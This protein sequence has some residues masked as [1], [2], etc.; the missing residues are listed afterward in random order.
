M[1]LQDVY[2]FSGS[3]LDNIRLENKSFGIEEAMQMARDLDIQ[4]FFEQLPGG[5]DFQIQERGN[6]LSHGQK[7]VISFLRAIVKNPSILILDE[8]TSSIDSNTEY[9]IQKLVQNTIKNKTSIVIAHRLSTIISSDKILV[10]DKGEIVGEG[11]H[12]TLIQ[13]NSYYKK[14]FKELESNTD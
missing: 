5:F 11:T 9:Y 6:S 13:S 10:L 3:I 14:Y 8:A 12:A 7:Q 1:V 4:D 2:L